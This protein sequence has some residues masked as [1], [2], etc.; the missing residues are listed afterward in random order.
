MRGSWTT[1]IGSI[2]LCVGRTAPLR[3]SESRISQRVQRG[4]AGSRGVATAG[5]CAPAI[6]PPSATI[7]AS[8]ATA[9][10]AA[11]PMVLQRSIVTS[12]GAAS[13]A[14]AAAS[15]SLLTAAPFA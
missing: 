14:V 2:S 3:S 15:R 11:P 8:I 13:Q 10:T 12:G 9:Q 4:I 1:P 5:V 7:P 6:R